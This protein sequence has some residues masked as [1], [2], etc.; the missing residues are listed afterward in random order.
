MA[1]V[2]PR[3][4]MMDATGP[5]ATATWGGATVPIDDVRV[6]PAN[7]RSAL[8]LLVAIACVLLI[9]CANV[10]SLL[11]ARMRHRRREIAVRTAL[12]A[13]AWRVARQLLTES[14]V[15]ACAGGVLGSLVAV[16]GV[17][18]VVLTAPSSL[19]STQTGYARVS[20]WSGCKSNC[21]GSKLRRSTRPHQYRRSRQPSRS[22]D[23]LLRSWLQVLDEVAR[24]QAVDVR[25]RAHPF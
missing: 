23:A 16:W 6:D 20:G 14:L 1:V 12:G 21:V 4:A 3:V 18:L 7:R 5:D 13:G 9:A 25:R 17:R 22:A 8:L 11:M 15:L 2:G 24:D 19:P 10:A